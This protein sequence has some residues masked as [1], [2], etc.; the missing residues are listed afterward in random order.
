M[1]SEPSSP[2]LTTDPFLIAGLYI[3]ADYQKVW[4]SFTTAEPY[5]H[6]SSASCLEFAAEP[7]GEVIWGDASRVVYRGVLEE[8]QPGQGLAHSF[9]FVGFGFE[10]PPTRV[11]IDITQEGPVTL[12]QLCHDCTDAPQTQRIVGSV[13][14]LKSLSRLKTWLET[15]TP[16]PWPVDSSE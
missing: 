16:M 11:A 13:G 5:E 3:A 7:G 4:D 6:W 2:A 8:I 9:Q 12:V 10:E 14:W 15:G 1:N